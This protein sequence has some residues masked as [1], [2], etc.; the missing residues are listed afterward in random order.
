MSLR[1]IPIIFAN[2]AGESKMPVPSMRSSMRAFTMQMASVL[3]VCSLGRTR[4][5]ISSPMVRGRS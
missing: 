1:L 4:D 5:A 3:C 2:A